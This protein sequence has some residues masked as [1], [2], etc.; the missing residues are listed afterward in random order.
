MLSN[1]NPPESPGLLCKPGAFH[2]HGTPRQ[3]LH[4]FLYLASQPLVTNIFRQLE[5]N[6]Q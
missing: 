2:D 1:G 3:T 6:L 4:M 5:F